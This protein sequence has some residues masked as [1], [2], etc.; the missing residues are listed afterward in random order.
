M[1][2]TAYKTQLADYI[3]AC[4][5]KPF[6]YSADVAKIQVF[7]IH[8]PQTF[9]KP[10]IEFSEALEKKLVEVSEIDESG[11]VQELTISNLSNSYL[12]IYEGTLLK[13][14]K[15]NR[16]INATQLIPPLSRHIIPASCIEQGRWRRT[17]STF[18]KSAHHSP[19][20]L[21]KAMREEI[22][23]CKSSFGSQSR[24]WSEIKAYSSSSGLHNSSSDFED[25]YHR[26]QSK[27]RV[28]PSGLPLPP[29]EGV[30]LQVNGEPSVDLIANT[31]A[32]E[33][34]LPQVIS[35]HEYAPVI[36]KESVLDSP[37]QTLAKEI[38]NG[39][40]YA[41]PAAAIGTD[42][43][44][45]SSLGYISALL[46]DGEVVSATLTGM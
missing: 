25:M 39:K 35:G 13:G 2:T 20:N 29:A 3:L 22:M 36:R 40:C 30:L 34:V 18:E 6:D 1:E 14:G 16:V 12:L 15:Q 27:N 43:R 44:I 32:F 24:V 31:S 23:Y 46:V 42:V 33:K 37:A 45:E 9:S 21:R 17:S 19:I 4:D 5:F 11:S 38:A 7:T 41:Q 26:N 28:F 8:T 10:V